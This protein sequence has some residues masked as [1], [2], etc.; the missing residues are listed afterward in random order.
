MI[1]RGLLL[2]GLMLMW[3]AAAPAAARAESGSDYARLTA[4]DVPAATAFLRDTMDCDVLDAGASR[5]LLQCGPGSVVEITRGRPAAGNQPALRLRT[6]NADATLGWLRQ[7][8]VPLVDDRTAGTVG[9]DGLLHIDVRTPWGQ[10]LELVGH[11]HA[12][13]VASARPLAVD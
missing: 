8:H 12:G 5:A 1:Q 2:S 3:L 10:T 9:A 6:E 7:R 4:P 11:G 13:P